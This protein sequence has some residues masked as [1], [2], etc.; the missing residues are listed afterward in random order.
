M[1]LGRADIERVNDLLD[2][3]QVVP[4]VPDDEHVGLSVEEQIGAVLF[5]DKF[6]DGLDDFDF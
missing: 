4:R 1:T 2:L 6:L 5:G 3:G